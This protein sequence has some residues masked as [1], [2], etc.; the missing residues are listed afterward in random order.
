MTAEAVD[1]A[2]AK[3]VAVRLVGLVRGPAELPVAEVVSVAEVV[4]VIAAVMVIVGV[5]VVTMVLRVVSGSR[6]ARVVTIAGAHAVTIAVVTVGGRV[7]MMVLRVVS[8]SRVARVVMI[9]GVRA[10]TIDGSSITRRRTLRNS[11]GPKCSPARVRANTAKTNRLLTARTVPSMWWTKV[12]FE[13][14]DSTLRN[15]NQQ[16]VVLLAIG[17][18]HRFP[19]PQRSKSRWRARSARRSVIVASTT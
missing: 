10:A 7:V 18:A 13:E 9:A 19:R 12:R 1:F 5:R 2:A 3:V 17:E 14:S 8:G 11:V 16:S 6:V 4:M 15:I